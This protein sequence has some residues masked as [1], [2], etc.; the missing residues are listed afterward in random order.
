MMYP[1]PFDLRSKWEDSAWV[2]GRGIMDILAYINTY[3][4]DDIN[5]VIIVLILHNVSVVSSCLL[6]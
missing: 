1:L 2:V 4:L 3:I 6:L 5:L